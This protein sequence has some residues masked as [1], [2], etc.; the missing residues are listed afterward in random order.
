MTHFWRE[1]CNFL[2]I[3]GRKMQKV[4]LN[5]GTKV[6]IHG[7]FFE[8]KWIFATLCKLVPTISLKST[9]KNTF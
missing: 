2:A 4:G 1:N 5:F 8:Q 9:I 6:L 7:Q 3:S